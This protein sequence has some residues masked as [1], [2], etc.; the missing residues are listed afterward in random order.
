MCLYGLNLNV[1]NMKGDV[2]L[3][4][5]IMDTV[6]IISLLLFVF[7]IERVGRRAFILTTAAVGDVACLSTILP[8]MLGSS[9]ECHSLQNSKHWFTTSFLQSLPYLV[10]P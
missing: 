4:F 2:F 5:A 7:L 9:G 8:T 10:T 6:D 3:N 1:S